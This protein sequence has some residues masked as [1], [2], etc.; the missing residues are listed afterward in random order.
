MYSDVGFSAYAKSEGHTIATITKAEYEKASPQSPLS[1]VPLMQ[2]SVN[3]WKKTESIKTVGVV[4]LITATHNLAE[5]ET[6]K[7]QKIV[8]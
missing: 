5:R 4:L 3:K 6:T 2:G 1:W 8:L 7:T